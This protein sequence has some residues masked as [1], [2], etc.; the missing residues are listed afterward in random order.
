[1]QTGSQEAFAQLVRMHVDMVS[2]VARRQLHDAHLAEDVTQ[3]VFVT[4]A[5]KAA[6]LRREVLLGG[7]LYTTARLSTAIDGQTWRYAD[8]RGKPPVLVFWRAYGRTDEHVRKFGDFARKWGKDPRLSIL[9][10]F[11]A[12]DEADARRVIAEAK[13]DFPQTGDT[14]LMGKFD[15]SW[16]EAVVVS[17]DGVILQKQ[18][19]DKVLEK[20]VNKA[21]AAATQPAR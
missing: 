16:P 19:H 15:S 9:G 14:L 3:K 12:V 1:M 20:Y 2:S 5:Q 11:S 6:T 21:L 17:A 8:H 7:W 4:L 10:C 18:L 13:L